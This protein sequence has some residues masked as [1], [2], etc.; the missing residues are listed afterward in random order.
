M[1]V[2]RMAT[3]SLKFFFFWGGRVGEEGIEKD[4]NID[5]KEKH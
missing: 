1:F 2:G 3:Q 4:K 5:V